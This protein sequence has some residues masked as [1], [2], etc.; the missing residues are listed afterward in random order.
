MTVVLVLMTSALYVI[1]W[2]VC[3]LIYS[4]DVLASQEEDE[5]I[6]EMTDIDGGSVPLCSVRE[7][8]SS[9]ATS[10][11]HI[12][13]QPKSVPNHASSGVAHDGLP[14]TSDDPRRGR[15]LTS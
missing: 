12:A 4:V 15:L 3:R 11:H 6:F 10:Q 7:D 13:A 1:C 8:S 5:T 2:H 14:Q 9:V